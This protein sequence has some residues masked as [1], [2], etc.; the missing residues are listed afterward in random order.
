MTGFLS[1][2]LESSSFFSFSG[3]ADVQ[4]A[5][6]L[7]AVFEANLGV[8]L[9]FQARLEGMA[10]LTATIGGN[11]DVIVDI[12]AACIPAIIAAAADAVLDV[13]AAGSATLSIAT[14]TK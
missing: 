6:K 2:F 3:A 10:K 14:A 1:D 7:Q 12:K 13:E 11:A 9:A 4:A 5:G 8:I